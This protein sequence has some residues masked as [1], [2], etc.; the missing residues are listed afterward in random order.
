MVTSTYALAGRSRLDTHVPNRYGSDRGVRSNC[1]GIIL[2]TWQLVTYWC[3]YLCSN[4][5]E[6]HIPS[7]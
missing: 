3:G 6:L 1:T 7:P 2:G 5:Q 4:L